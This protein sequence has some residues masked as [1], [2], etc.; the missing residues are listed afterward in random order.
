MEVKTLKGNFVLLEAAG[1]DCTVVD[2]Y[3]KVSAI[4]ATPP[5]GKW[6]LLLIVKSSR[7]LKPISDQDRMLSDYG[8][9]DH[10]KYRVEVILDMGACHTTGK[11]N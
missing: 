8:A 11:R 2:L 4:E 10:E 9:V 1:L 6:K 5:D 3:E 7:T